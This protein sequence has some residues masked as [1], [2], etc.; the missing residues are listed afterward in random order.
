MEVINIDD[1][2]SMSGIEDLD[3][4]SSPGFEEL[5]P[6]S[7]SQKPAMNDDESEDEFRM[8]DETLDVDT[9]PA[10]VP[11]LTGSTSH[12]TV[13]TR[14]NRSKKEDKSSDFIAFKNPAY[15]G[16]FW[17]ALVWL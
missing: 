8:S 9:P 4:V 5:E 11:T 12:R 2:E 10:A 6:V 1:G 17:P 16:V 15:S 7:Q 13:I 14:A 3:P